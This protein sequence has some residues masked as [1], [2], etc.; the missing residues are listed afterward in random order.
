MASGGE[1]V[2]G[3]RSGAVHRGMEQPMVERVATHRTRRIRLGV[4]L[5]L[6]SWVPAPLVVHVIVD[7]MSSPPSASVQHTMTALAWIC[8]V[9]IGL[10]G[11]WLAGAEAL[12]VMRSVGWR[13][14]PSAVWGVLVHGG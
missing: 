3:S 9:L 10:V 12:S 2:L 4:V 14:T 6:L 1:P 13:Q 11:A 7:L 8:E 5:M